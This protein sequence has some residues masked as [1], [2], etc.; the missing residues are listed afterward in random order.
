MDNKYEKCI[1]IGYKY[2]LNGHKIWNPKT[3][4]VFSSWYVIIKEF[5]DVVKQKFPLMEKEL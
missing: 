2:G 3:K 1:F 5:K 4:K